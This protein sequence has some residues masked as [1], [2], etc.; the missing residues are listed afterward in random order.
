MENAMEC[1]HPD[2]RADIHV[3]RIVDI[4]RWMAEIKITCIKC[5]LPFNFFGM[6][7][8]LDYNGVAMSA[9]GKEAFLAIAP[10]SELPPFKG[11][12]GFTIKRVAC[13]DPSQN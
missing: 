3:A 10:S 1:E 2:F 4:D 13:P 7:T 11:P 12:Q 5:H 9:D 8:G 6:P